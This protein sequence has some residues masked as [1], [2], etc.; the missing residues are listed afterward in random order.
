LLSFPRSG[1]ALPDYLPLRKRVNDP[2]VAAGFALVLVLNLVV[3][4][5]MYVYWG[6]G[7]G[8][9]VLAGH[10]KVRDEFPLGGG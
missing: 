2:L 3:G 5:Q 1:A 8:A 4:I 7:S 10:E 9:S 6:K